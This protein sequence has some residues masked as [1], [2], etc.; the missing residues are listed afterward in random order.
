M[1]RSIK[2]NKKNRVTKRYSF[3]SYAGARF[4]IN[5]FYSEK[6]NRGAQCIP[7]MTALTIINLITPMIIIIAC[8]PQSE[9]NEQQTRMKHANDS[10]ASR[11]RIKRVS[12]ILL[13]CFFFFFLFL[14]HLPLHEETGRRKKSAAKKIKK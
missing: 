5:V 7:I 4:I 6:L 3:L 12:F 11:A 13:V 8:L 2:Y 1:R 9:G 14:I 10:S